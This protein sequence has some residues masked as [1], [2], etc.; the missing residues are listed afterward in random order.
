MLEIC[1]T[2]HDKVSYIHRMS[3]FGYGAQYHFQQY[4][5]YIVAVEETRE[6]HRPVASHRQFLSHKLYRVHLAMS[7]ERY[8]NSHFSGDGHWLHRQLLIQIPYDHDHEGP[9]AMKWGINITY[10]FKRKL[11]HTLLCF[12]YPHFY[13]MGVRYCHRIGPYCCGRSFV[14]QLQLTFWI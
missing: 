10:I 7:H 5:S 6:N 14:G 1:T 4:F 12:S 13:L 2:S 3:S 8:S 9:Y 11:L